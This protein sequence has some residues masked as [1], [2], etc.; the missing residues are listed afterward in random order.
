MAEEGVGWPSGLVAPAHG[1]GTGTGRH[2]QE[3][4][5]EVGGRRRCLIFRMPPVFHVF[6]G[7]FFCLSIFHPSLAWV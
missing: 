3:V 1:T 5:V 7:G 4:G 6:F 2:G